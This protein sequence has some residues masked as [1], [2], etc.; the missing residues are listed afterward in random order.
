MATKPPALTDPFDE[1][2]QVDPASV[3][4]DT[5]ERVFGMGV[6]P[7]GSL[8]RALQQHHQQRIATAQMYRKNAA[9]AIG[10]I[11]KGTKWDPTLN[12][13][14]GGERPLTE[15]EKADLNAQKDE[16]LQQYGKIVGVNKESKGAL[17]KAHGII[18]FI[19]GRKQQ[20]DQQ[21]RPGGMAPPPS[22]GLSGTA[23]GPSQIEAA[24]PAAQITPP[25]SRQ[26]PS[27][28]EQSI[29]APFIQHEQ[30]VGQAAIDE[31]HYQSMGVQSR[32]ALVK[33]IGLDESKPYIQD[34]IL[35]GRITG[36]MAAMLRPPPRPAG[37]YTT[38]VLDAR[39]RAGK[40]GEL[41]LD[42]RGNPI[43]IDSLD[44]SMG[45]KGMQV[46]NEDTRQWEV[47][48]E[49]FSPNQSTITVGNEVMAVN[50]ADKS[51]LGTGAGAVLGPKQ[52]PTTT[53]TTDP[54]TMQTTVTT[55]TPQ[56]PGITGRPGGTALPP[57]PPGAG[58]APKPSRQGGVGG[59]GGPS[60][61]SQIPTAAVPALDETGHIPAT[62]AVGLSPQIV[63]G[64]NQ[65]LDGKDVKDIPAKTKELSASLA[66][67]YGWEQGK[68]T[69]REQGALR[70]ATQ[71]ID[72][73][74]SDPSTFAVLD[75][76]MS[77]LKLNQV[78]HGSGK[79]GTVGS[80]LSTIAAQNMTDQEARFVRQYNI[81]TQTLAGIAPAI[82]G[83][84]NRTTEAAIQRLLTDMPNPKTVQG[85]KDGIERLQLL[86]K[87][88]ARA[89]AKGQ[90]TEAQVEAP[91]GGRMA[92]P[93]SPTGRPPLSS[94]EH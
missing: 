93:P 21:Q 56:T 24:V 62:A 55:R 63:E 44:D 8:D 74:L 60:K 54:A 57:A 82:R 45:L 88:V 40:T 25:P 19:L 33:Q 27:A 89:L 12:G 16:A 39:S 84:G 48:Y 1:A 66:R 73:M 41:F 23:G 6:T 31:Q 28:L 87:E 32:R 30:R 29:S 53:R 17:D 78:L 4:R 50:P 94:F 51:K 85:S 71:F 58:P 10:Q 70:N 26:Q 81:I 76:T 46:L 13:G 47:R 49:P 34:F 3:G 61:P 91:S 67:K 35:T 42:S 36:N 7:G 68:F 80:T 90:F 15:D 38:S 69:P 18:D 43:D 20:Q 9:T 59:A 22:V 86:K 65:L 77:R 52:V 75:S 2:S 5:T 92:P 64:A 83:S 79:Q 14:V 11:A 37:S 72:D